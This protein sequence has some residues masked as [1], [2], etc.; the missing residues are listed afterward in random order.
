[1]THSRPSPPIRRTAR[2]SAIAA[3]IVAAVSF[4]SASAQEADASAAATL[5][6]I[7][8]VGRMRSLSSFP[9]AVSVVDGDTLR[10]GQRQVSLAETL[11][12]VPGVTVLDRQNYAQDLQ[13]QSRG[14]GARSTFG[15]RGIRLIV[16]GIPLS[17]ADGQG[18]AGSFPLDTLDRIEVLRGPL[19]LQYGNAAGGAI[20]GYTELDG[21]DRQSVEGWLGSDDS[22]RIGARI[23]GSDADDRLRWR[24]HGSRFETDGARP[25]SAAERS[26]FSAVAQWTP[27]EGERLRLVL[28]A[29][30]QPDTQD[31]LGLTREAWQR[32]PHGTDPAAAEFDT[33]KRIENHQLGLGWQR[34]YAPGRE[35]WVNGH[36]IHRDVMQFLSVPVFAQA[37]ASSAGGVIDIMR[38][39]S[40]VDAGHRWRDER[41]AVAVG[42]ELSRLNEARTGYENFIGSASDEP[43]L[44]VRGRLRRNEDNRVD[45]REAYVIGDLT[46][47]PQWTALGAVRHARLTF[48]SDDHYI[49]PGNGDGSGQ[50]DYRETAASLGIARA[51]DSGEVFASIGRGFETPTITESAYRP[52]GESGFNRDLVPAHFVSAEIGARWRFAT[53]TASIAAY[54]VDGEDEIVPAQSSGGRTSYANA[55]RTRRD[56]IEAGLDGRFGRQWSYVLTAN[57]IRAR[58]EQDFS[59]RVTRGQTEVR[60]VD[61]GNRIPGIPSAHG[62]AELAWRTPSQRFSTA[63]E[64]RVSDRIPTDD[65]NTDAAPGHARFSL[66]AQWRPHGAGG[67]YG[68]ARVDNLLDR[69][70][71]GSVIVND[72]NGRF[73]EPGPGRSFTVGLGW[74]SG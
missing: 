53:A 9:G 8:V 24:V 61:A 45:S 58:F 62:Y 16:D 60:T 48:T 30:S 18:Q 26:Q 40:G 3:A 23:D 72:G 21:D 46:L 41:G 63:V 19:A 33:R 17:A 59:Y 67:W 37:P 4:P 20:V 57:F 64:A 29:L 69:D 34:D 51:F 42:V 5:D 68:F 22:Y 39:S 44:G 65:R 36:R 35:A 38:R 27:R 32:D 47:T 7:E 25:H 52:D 49:V 56:G 6:R 13:I 74:V 28:N 2:G 71:I 43:V 10:D 11:G 31:P 55:G 73:F 54:R 14:F 66:R 70:Y 1:M 50:T 15:I 12:R